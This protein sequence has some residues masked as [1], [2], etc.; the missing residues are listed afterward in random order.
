MKE[1]EGDEL[2]ISGKIEGKYVV[3][4]NSS[5]GKGTVVHDLVTIKNSI[6]GENNKIWN[7]VNIYNSRIGNSNKISSFVEIGGSEIGDDCK[8]EAF[9]YIPPSTKIGNHVFLGPRVSIANDKYP[10]ADPVWE[11]GNVTI[12]DNCSIGMGAE[13]LPNV[14]IE[15]NCFIAAGSLV[16]KN[17]PAFS[18]AVG[19]PAH[20]VSKDVFKKTVKWE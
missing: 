9:V 16:T 8:I 20:A 1:K 7:L 15:K 4:E 6:I 2:A 5:V 10:Q 18:F 3:I 11:I 19:R 13:I 14:L 12:K 17:L